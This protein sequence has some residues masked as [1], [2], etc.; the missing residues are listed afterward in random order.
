MILLSSLQDL[1][2]EFPEGYGE[3]EPVVVRKEEAERFIYP[4]QA[5]HSDLNKLYASTN[6]VF[7]AVYTL[8]PGARFLPEDIHAGDEV[9]FVLSGRL[10]ILNPE[11]GEVHK[12][13]EGDGLLIP[14]NGWH[15]GFN[16]EEKTVDILA[17]VAPDIWP[18]EG[19]PED[20]YP[21]EPKIL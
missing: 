9:Y 15:T 13:T 6:K 12:L 17:I 21:D 7:T 11:T 19:I 2:E 4:N 1:L 14:E 16:F 5:E 3:K 10:T 8:S 18:P 20:G